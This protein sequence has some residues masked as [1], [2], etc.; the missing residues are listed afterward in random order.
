[1]SDFR[2]VFSL[3]GSRMSY[4]GESILLYEDSKEN[5]HVKYKGKQFPID[6]DFRVQPEGTYN[7][8][9]TEVPYFLIGKDVYS[10]ES[11]ESVRDEENV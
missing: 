7:Q 8:E 3:L 2:E 5:F 1:M 10:F 11:F 4:D 6:V 9:T